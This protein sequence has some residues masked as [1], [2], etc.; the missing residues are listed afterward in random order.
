M[1]N[2]YILGINIIIRINTILNEK[3]VIHNV[4]FEFVILLCITILLIVHNRLIPKIL[5]KLLIIRYLF[6][7]FLT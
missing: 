4:Y 1:Y 3:P 6:V 5:F 2:K 7:L